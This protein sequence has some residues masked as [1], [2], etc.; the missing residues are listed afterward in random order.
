MAERSIDDWSEVSYVSLTAVDNKEIEEANKRNQWIVGKAIA[1]V[2]LSLMT[3]VWA[4]LAV[5]FLL[6]QR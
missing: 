5:A 6:K 3:S 1:K 4:K 2:T